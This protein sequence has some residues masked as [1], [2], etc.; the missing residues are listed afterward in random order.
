MP[1]DPSPDTEPSRPSGSPVT[2]LPS[3]NSPG[4]VN[5]TTVS[6]VLR[7]D[8]Q[9]PPDHGWT[10]QLRPFLPGALDNPSLRPLRG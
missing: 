10:A 2:V 8:S 6:D 7:P 1:V 3:R 9:R 5:S 4:P